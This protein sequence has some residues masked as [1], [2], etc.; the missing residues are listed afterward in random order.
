MKPI[1]ETFKEGLIL[2]RFPF[3]VICMA[4]LFL[5]REVGILLCEPLN[6][7]QKFNKSCKVTSLLF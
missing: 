5:P 3:E 7:H 6:E 1:T 2:I 4:L